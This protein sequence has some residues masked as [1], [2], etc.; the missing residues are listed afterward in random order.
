MT[1]TTDHLEALV[2]AVLAVNNYLPGVNYKRA[3]TTVTL[4]PCIRGVRGTES[5]PSIQCPAVPIG[6]AGSFEARRADP[7]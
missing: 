1:L 2:A 5:P 4:D 3:V 6:A 7:P